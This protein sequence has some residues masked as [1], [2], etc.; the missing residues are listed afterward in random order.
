V[1]GNSTDNSE[2]TAPRCACNGAEPHDHDPDWSCPLKPVRPTLAAEQRGTWDDP[3][4]VKD[5]RIPH[6]DALVRKIAE[7]LHRNES[8]HLHWYISSVVC[9][10]CALRASVA[11]RMVRS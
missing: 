10:Y 5:D 4:I 7:A 11:V 2:I 3:D 1:S 8:M 6:E 9:P